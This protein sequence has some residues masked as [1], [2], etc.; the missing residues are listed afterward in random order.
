MSSVDQ[1]PLPKKGR[2]QKAATPSS[3]VRTVTSGSAPR[4]AGAGSP[5]FASLTRPGPVMRL[6]ARAVT[7][8]PGDRPAP[9]DHDHPDRALDHLAL[10]AHRLPVAAEAPDL[11]G[12]D[13]ALEGVLH[14]PGVA[15]PL[16]LRRVPRHLPARR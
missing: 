12:P 4:V 13:E 8:A 2:H 10:L 16:A 15:E 3:P 5:S 11:T 7:A 1:L 14:G 9:V 6:P